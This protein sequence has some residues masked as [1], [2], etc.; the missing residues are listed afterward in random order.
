M[1][2]ICKWG[3][4]IVISWP[5]LPNLRFLE[6]SERQKSWLLDPYLAEPAAYWS[7]KVGKPADLP[8]TGPSH[9]SRKPAVGSPHE[10]TWHEIFWIFL[11]KLVG[12]TSLPKQPFV[13]CKCKQK[14]SKN[15]SQIIWQKDPA[16][17]LTNLRSGC[18]NSTLGPRVFPLELNSYPAA[19]HGLFFCCLVVLSK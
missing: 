2:S 5:N 8:T 9:L 6:V 19:P 18:R 12:T 15:P 17:D 1:H 13:W 7:S 16:D 10:S 3:R 4:W 14:T 11:R